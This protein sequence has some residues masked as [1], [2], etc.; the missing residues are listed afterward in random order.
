MK[1]TELQE[2][3]LQKFYEKRKDGFV[4]VS[5]ANF[6]LSCEDQDV[7]RISELLSQRGIIEWK[8]L[9]NRTG[10]GGDI[11]AGMGK[12]N[13]RGIRAIEGKT[14]TNLTK[15]NSDRTKRILA[16]R[17]RVVAEFNSG[18]WAEVGLLTGH[19]S[20]I[21]GHSRLL[22]SLSFGDEDYSGNVLMIIVGISEQDEPALAVFEQFVAEKYPGDEQ[23][24]SAKPSAR[25]ITFAPHVFHVPE[26]TEIERDLV[27]VMMPFS[28]AFEIVQA[29][30]KKACNST[31]FRCLRVDDIW[32]NSAIIQDIFSL[33][34]RSY[35]VIVDFTGKNS[36]VM[37]ETG[38]AHTLGKHVVPICQSLGDVPFDMQHHR[39]LQYLPN[40]EGIEAM[41]SSLAKKLN[42]IKAS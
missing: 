40:I 1:D 29:G 3:V 6:G 19:S 24:I 35:V 37:Y 25:T 15:A 30:I 13:E 22:R 23:Y 34:F 39:A 27:A 21:N 31:N 26:G 36:N 33:I 8:S 16:L 11:A 20:L 42:H 38:I 17:D 18:D 28:K 10:L 12:I 14:S 4:K 32:E 5:A 9:P 7:L 2:I 41:V